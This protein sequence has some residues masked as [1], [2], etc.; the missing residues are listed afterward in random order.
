MTFHDG[1]TCGLALLPF[2]KGDG[3]LLILND[4]VNRALKL[5]RIGQQELTFLGGISLFKLGL[6][7]GGVWMPY[8]MYA[9]ENQVFI[10]DSTYNV[11]QVY[12]Y[13]SP[14]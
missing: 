11:V 1:S 4:L 6:Q 12:R 13:S 10:A 2:W 14:S 8:F 7:Q 3:D 5:F 9:H